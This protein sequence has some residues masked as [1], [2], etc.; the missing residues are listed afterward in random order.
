MHV[1]ATSPPS[2]CERNHTDNMGNLSLKKIGCYVFYY[3][4]A[5]NQNYRLNDKFPCA[6]RFNRAVDPIV[7]KNRQHTDEQTL[8]FPH[9]TTARAALG[10]AHLRRAYPLLAQC[11]ARMPRCQLSEEGTAALTRPVA[12]L[13]WPLLC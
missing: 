11:H 3:A 1:V 5:R 9:T 6:Y 8:R 13:P 4:L 7:L 12:S 10:T 2:R